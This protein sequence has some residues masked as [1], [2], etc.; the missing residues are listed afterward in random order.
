MS[1]VLR[2]DR[3]GIATLTLN[4]P[5]RRNALSS[6]LVERLHGALSEVEADP[7]VRVVVLTGA[8]AVFCA[9]GDLGGG[10]LGGEGV[11]AMEQARRQFGG[12]LARL[13]KLS[14]PVVAAVQ[15]DALGGGLGL[16]AA[17]DLAILDPAAQVGTPEVHVGL[18]PL[19][20]SAVLQRQVARKP[21]ME[22]MLTGAK[23]DAHRA[24]ALGLANRVSAPGAALAEA[25]ELAATLA[26]R[27]RAVLALGKAAFHQ[28]ADLPYEAAL[29]MLNGRLTVNLLMEDASEGMA[30][31]A[32]KR[33]P[34]WRD[35]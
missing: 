35:R 32:Q 16:L 6:E 34:R 11:L 31:F 27:S 24:V 23:V 2:D 18:F 28:A 30:A 4:R 7:Q 14:R 20:I 29:E 25:N 15:G 8:G 10:L 13:P 9:G 5:E 3:D 26:K 1:V 17:C 22:L 21:L 33:P 12:L 19:V